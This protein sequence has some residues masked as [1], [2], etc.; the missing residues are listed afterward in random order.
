MFRRVG[1]SPHTPYTQ[2]LMDMTFRN[3]APLYGL[4]GFKD[5][6]DVNVYVQGGA[7][8]DDDAFDLVINFQN[9]RRDVSAAI[10]YINAVESTWTWLIGPTSP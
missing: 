6:R 3:Y 4:M 8:R 1:F 7:T 2:R 9:M 10:T 5:P